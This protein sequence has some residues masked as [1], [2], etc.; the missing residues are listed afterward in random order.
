MIKKI[1]IGLSAFLLLSAIVSCSNSAKQKLEIREAAQ[2][3][4]VLEAGIPVLYFNKQPAT[5]DGKYERAG[6]IHPLYDLEG[7]VLTEN[8]PADH[9]HHRGVFWAWHQVFLNG[10]Q[11]G[12]GWVS[13]HIRFIPQQLKTR[14][15]GDDILLDWS[16]TWQADSVKGKQ[17]ALIAEQTLIRVQPAND[18]VRLI[19]FD[20]YLRPLQDSVAIGG[21]ND[22]KGYGGFSMRWKL[23]ADLRFETRDSM[24]QPQEPA[25]M[26]A[27]WMQFRGHFNGEKETAVS[28]LCAAP[29][30]GPDQSWILR[31]P[32]AVSMQNAVYPGRVP[33][34]LAKEGLH[35]R[36]RLVVQRHPL[37]AATLENL[38][39]QYEQ[40][41][42]V[43]N[44]TNA[45]Q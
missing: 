1:T 10:K 26:G 20:I 39:K 41:K 28:L 33:V 43:A 45:S 27:P 36:Y 34:L 38:W 3:V 32:D 25:V 29:Y 24:V 15:S 8:G 6:F 11:V 13:E 30:P 17:V 18:S 42:P 35:L 7:K 2:G 5:I 14:Q 31:G 37:T 12:D 19:D 23:P 9:P 22:I 21:S 16:M 40:E 4:E 44:S